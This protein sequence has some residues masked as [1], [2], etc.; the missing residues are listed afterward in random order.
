MTIYIM[1]NHENN[2]DPHLYNI[3]EP[4]ERQAKSELQRGNVTQIQ[5]PTENYHKEYKQTN[6]QCLCK[7][8]IKLNKFWLIK[9]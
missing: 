2:L 4:I 1:S 3:K 9:S 6:K 7:Q 8:T 5:R